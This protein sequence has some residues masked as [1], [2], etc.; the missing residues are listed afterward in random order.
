MYRGHERIRLGA[1]RGL[2]RAYLKG[3]DIMI[4]LEKKDP[5]IEDSRRYCIFEKRICRYAEKNGQA[6]E[7]QCPS[8][9]QMTCRR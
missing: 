3:G 1:N 8:D 7:C 2:D 9:D 5:R 4:D 6:F